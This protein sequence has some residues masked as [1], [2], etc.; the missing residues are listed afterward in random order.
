MTEK[1]RSLHIN[2]GHGVEPENLLPYAGESKS[3]SKAQKLSLR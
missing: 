3:M 2:A 1:A